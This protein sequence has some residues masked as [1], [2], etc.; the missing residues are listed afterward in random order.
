MTSKAFELSQLS[1]G[2]NVKAEFG[3]SSD[4]QIYHSGSD[5]WVE[6]NGTGNLYIDTNGAGVNITYNNSAE[7]MAAFTANGAASLYYDS[8]LKF[9]TSSVGSRTDNL[10]GISD[11]DTGIALGSNGANIMQFYTGNNERARLDASGNLLVGASSFSYSGSNDCVQINSAEGRID[12]E[13]DTTGTVYNIA[14]YNPNGNVGKI[15][16]NGSSTNYATSSD[17]RLKE[18]VEDLTDAVDRLKQLDPKRF[19]FIVDADTV[20][21][22]FL[23]HE[24]QSVVP[25]AVTGVKDE[26]DDEGNA[27]MQGIDQGKLVPLLTAALQEA[28]TKIETLETKVAALESE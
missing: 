4:L 15:T 6:D 16:T 18:N 19:N 25:E 13:N 10:W 7:N 3:A 9:Q 14:F 11:T 28:I 12:I 5:S 17:Y 26:V 2:D 24:V 22:G 21:D 1:F 27:I 20:V 23:A 8:S